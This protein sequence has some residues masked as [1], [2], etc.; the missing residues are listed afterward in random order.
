MENEFTASYPC[1]DTA[2]VVQLKLI[3]EPTNFVGFPSR[4]VHRSVFLTSQSS[5][6]AGPWLHSTA[7]GYR[8]QFR[9][10]TDRDMDLWSDSK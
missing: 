5:T 10:L 9:T 8:P 7:S 3:E 2:S 6:P 1:G 4:A